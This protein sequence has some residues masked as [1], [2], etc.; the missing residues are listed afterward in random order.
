MRIAP[1]IVSNMPPHRV[2]LE[3]YFGSGAVFFGKDPAKVEVLNDLDGDVADLFRM[4]RERPDELAALVEKTPWAREEY[5]AAYSR[6]GDGLEDARRFIVRCY[7]SFGSRTGMKTG[8]RH[9]GPVRNGSVTGRWNA[10]PD[11]IVAVA[12]RLKNAEI[13][14]K[15]ALSL[16]PAYNHKDV[17]IYADPPYMLETRFSAK[18]Y[19]YETTDEHHIELLRLLK[20]HKGTVLLSGYDSGLYRAELGGWTLTTKDAYA[21]CGRPRTECLWLNPRAAEAMKTQ[22]SFKEATC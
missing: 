9:N 8:W 16:I 18:M 7:Q 13:E 5:E 2:Y 14:S 21:E 17:L 4:I 12:K 3:P 19:A 6:T 1:W 22:I 15:D 10:L 11:E 20:A